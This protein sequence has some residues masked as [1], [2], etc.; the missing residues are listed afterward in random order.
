MY[1]IYICIIIHEIN[2]FPGP[3]MTYESKKC[4]Q[5]VFVDHNG[6]FNTV[7]YNITYAIT[8]NKFQTLLYVTKAHTEVCLIL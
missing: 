2:I 6:T 3:L 8:R 5:R 7:H 1:C 4:F